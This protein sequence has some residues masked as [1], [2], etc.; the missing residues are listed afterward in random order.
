MAFTA[1]DVQ[2]LREST[3]AGMMD[4]KKALQENDGDMEKAIGFL[5]EKGL[6]AAAKKA[7]R[8]AA[9]GAVYGF[10]NDNGIGAVVEINS[11]TDFVA[12]NDDFQAFVKNVAEVVAGNNPAD[13]DALMA[14]PFPGGSLTVAEM[15][16]EKVLVI[17]E[18]IQ[19]RRFCRYD[20]GLTVPYVHMGGKIGVLVNMEVSQNIFDNPEVTELGRDLAMQIAAMR[21]I[22]LSSN[23]ADSDTVEKEKEIIAAQVKN[24]DKNKNKPPQVI[25]KIVEGRLGKYFS[26]I[27]LLNQ[28]FVKE[29]SLS[30]EKY[31]EQKAKELGGSIKIVKFV[32]FEKGEGLEKRADNFAD[33]VAGMIK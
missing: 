24:D 33:E 5:R 31:V 6:A 10:V 15:L 8:I 22:W 13:M 7:G 16:R 27:C 26:E 2:A 32:R 11:E 17:G 28:P 20:S 9:E 4:C 18:N 30:V 21:P 23:E 12:K 1:K 25:D 3:G 14:L 19:I 29:N